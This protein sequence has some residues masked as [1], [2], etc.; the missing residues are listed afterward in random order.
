M[1]ARKIFCGGWIG[2][3]AM[4][5]VACGGSGSSSE[6]PLLGTSANITCTQNQ[7]FEGVV[8]CVPTQ[9][10]AFDLYDDLLAAA[11]SYGVDETTELQ[12]IAYG[13][14]GGNG[15]T[16]AGG[17][18]GHG[19]AGG[20]ANT[21]TTV[22]DIKNAKGTTTV[23]WLWGKDGSHT[24]EDEEG[25]SGGAATMIWMADD[26]TTAPSESN[27]LVIAAGGGGGT[28]SD[29]CE[30]TGH[31]GGHGGNVN[32]SGG[33][34]NG[35]Y[36]NYKVERNG[37]TFWVGT[38][39][40]GHGDGGNPGSAPGNPGIGGQPYHADPTNGAGLDGVG[41]NGGALLPEQDSGSGV[42]SPGWDGGSVDGV[43]L[44]GKTGI[45][46]AQINDQPSGAG[47]GG[48][49][50]GGAGGGCNGCTGGGAGG[51]SFALADTSIGN[52]PTWPHQDSNVVF[53]FL[54]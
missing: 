22:G 30:F 35:N 33:T 40:N 13:G 25:G 41:G 3:V 50:G 9:N 8:Y 51:G 26:S 4:G 29:C 24:Q 27:A 48:Y 31:D 7:P 11:Q 36:A 6:Q 1:S 15:T 54:P 5:A 38:G 39:E 12:V 44:L 34:S 23:Q 37:V 10:A 32:G 49:G 20:Y 52:D 53:I 43:A 42:D 14:S 45:G 2:L 17:T 21:I 46:G 28:F 47:G 16:E 18:T 19:G